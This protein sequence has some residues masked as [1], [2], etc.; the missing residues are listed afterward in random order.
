V[1]LRGVY[2]QDDHGGS[3]NLWL[4]EKQQDLVSVESGVGR[5]VET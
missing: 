4:N 2:T 5:E 3:G 1:R